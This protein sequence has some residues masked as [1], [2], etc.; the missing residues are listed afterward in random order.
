[1]IV[2]CILMPCRLDELVRYGKEKLDGDSMQLESKEGI[3]CDIVLKDD[4]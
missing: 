2:S 1:M 3:V 4:Q